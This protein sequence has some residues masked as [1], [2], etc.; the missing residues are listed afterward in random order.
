MRTPTVVVSALM[1]AALVLSASAVP[2]GAEPSPPLAPICTAPADFLHLGQPLTRT[3]LALAS[4]EPLVIVAIG[5]SSTAG[6]GATSPANSYPS[7][8]EAELR[9]RFPGAPIT[10]INRGANGEDA[11]QMIARFDE[12]IRDQPDLV[13]WQVGTNAVLRDYAVSG[14]APLILEGIRRL[15]AAQTDIVL[16]D[17]QYA[18][19]VITKHDIAGMLALL[20][21]IARDEKVG[22]FE[23]FA[24]MRNWHN[25]RGIPFEAVLSPD[26]LHMNDWSYGCVA[27]LLAE[28]ITQA[29]RGAAIAGG[30]RRQR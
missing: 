20:A 30:P 9:E 28:S 23:R 12:V 2:T 5:S 11:K 25:D 3:A 10:V 6:A 27:K 21:K 22:L 14:E 4:G 15:K 24:I 16:V 17:S 26:G 8:L 7:R 1:A 19:K 13:L 29:V 18:P